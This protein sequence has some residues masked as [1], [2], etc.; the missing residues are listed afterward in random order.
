MSALAL[1]VSGASAEFGV[2]GPFRRGTWV[3]ALDFWVQSEGASR[4]EVVAGWQGTSDASQATV[5]SSRPVVDRS[6]H[7]ALGFV[8]GQRPLS[9]EWDV[10]AG[11]LRHW[12]LPVGVRVASGGEYIGVAVDNVDPVSTGDA[13]ITAE[14]VELL[15]VGVGGRGE[16]AMARAV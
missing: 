6:D 7:T 11:E 15:S 9:V 8:S 3:V 1:R 12:R 13:L 10:I 14:V 2:L 5:G 4:W 16:V